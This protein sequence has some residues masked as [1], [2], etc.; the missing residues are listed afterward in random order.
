MG[1]GIGVRV[2]RSCVVAVVRKIGMPEKVML[3]NSE[4]LYHLG[5]QWWVRVR[6]CMFVCT[7]LLFRL[8][9]HVLIWR[10]DHDYQWFWYPSY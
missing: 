5:E 9:L 1:E 10:S 8:V 2:V 3:V 7:C 6:T 4:V